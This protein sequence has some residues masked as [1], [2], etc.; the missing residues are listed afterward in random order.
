MRR[1]A[2][3]MITSALVGVAALIWLSVRT[4]VGDWDYSDLGI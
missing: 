4:D 3:I 1:V 2:G